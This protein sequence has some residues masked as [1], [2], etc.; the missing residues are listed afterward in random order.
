MKYFGSSLA[1]VHSSSDEVELLESRYNNDYMTWI[2]LN[3]INGESIQYDQSLGNNLWEWSDGSN[4]NFAVNWTSGEP[5][6]GA[7]SGGDDQDCAV[8]DGVG[9]ND[10][11]CWYSMN[12]F[13]CGEQVNWRPIFKINNNVSDYTGAVSDFW[14]S[15]SSSSFSNYSADISYILNTFSP[16]SIDTSNYRS[17]AIDDWNKFYLNNKFDQIKVS[18]YKNGSEVKYFIY[19]ATSDS[20]SWYSQ[21][22]L[23]D[24]S[25]FNARTGT[26]QAWVVTGVQQ[27]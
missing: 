5:D 11:P 2:G 18:L 26:A 8:Y 20:S 12:Q 9:V 24:S 1:S 14:G 4:V 27:T 22:N 15:E 13:I 3:D 23:I 21:P 25:Y 10:Y 6:N 16:S 17:L 7:A 19:N